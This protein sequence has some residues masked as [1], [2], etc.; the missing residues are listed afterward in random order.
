MATKQINDPHHFFVFLSSSILMPRK[1][2]AVVHTRFNV[3]MM[4]R[5]EIP[6][7]HNSMM[8]H[9]SVNNSEVRIISLRFQLNTCVF[10]TNAPSHL[11]LAKRGYLKCVY[12]S[13]IIIVKLPK[14]QNT[15][16]LTWYI[17]TVNA[18]YLTFITSSYLLA[19]G[20]SAILTSRLS[21]KPH[22]QPSWRSGLSHFTA[23]FKT[24]LQNKM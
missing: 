14:T 8:L 6:V 9:V 23:S 13:D 21:L 4:Q 18:S 22:Q 7:P 11:D 17:L 1:Y 19:P 24:S 5:R 2:F 10:I 20:C 3:R 16:N 12:S 15:V